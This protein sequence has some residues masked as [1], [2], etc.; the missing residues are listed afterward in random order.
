[1]ATIDTYIDPLRDA[2]SQPELLARAVTGFL[3]SYWPAERPAEIEE[4]AWDILGD[5]ALDLEYL[6]PNPEWRKEDKSFFG[7]ERAVVEIRAALERLLDEC[8]IKKEPCA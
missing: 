3:D 4:R 2:I 5:L 6:V 8:G 7:E 1:M